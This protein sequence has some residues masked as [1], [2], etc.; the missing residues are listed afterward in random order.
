MRP[1]QYF[2]CVKN[3]VETYL[4]LLREIATAAAKD[5]SG[6]IA[7]HLS[8]AGVSYRWPDSIPLFRITI[9]GLECVFFRV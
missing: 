2:G 6:G 4:D 1:K 9:T 3:K 5:R 8:R 7:A